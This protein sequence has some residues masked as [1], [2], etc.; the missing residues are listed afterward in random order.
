MIQE[1]VTLPLPLIFCW[2]YFQNFFHTTKAALCK[3][4][5]ADSPETGLSFSLPSI[6]IPMQINILLRNTWLPRFSRY[7]GPST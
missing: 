2:D 3:Y 4:I 1:S 5:E 7:I 6:S